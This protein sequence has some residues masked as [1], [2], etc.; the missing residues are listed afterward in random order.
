MGIKLRNVCFS[1]GD[2][3]VLRDVTLSVETG[4]QVGIVGASGG[5]KSTLLKL[6]AG[7]YAPGRGEIAVAGRHTPV[8]IRREVA[9]VPQSNLLFPATIRENITCG[10]PMEEARVLAACRAAQLEN[11]VSSLPLGLDAPVGERGGK[12]SGGQAQRIA[13]ARALAKDAPVVLLDEATSSLDDETGGAVLEAL[14]RLTWGR[15][16]VHVAHRP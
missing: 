9:L 15:T 11:W 8:E 6:L 3:Q 16:V 7:L 12:V 10:H 1:Y 4:E 13:I 5:G 2:R 14:A